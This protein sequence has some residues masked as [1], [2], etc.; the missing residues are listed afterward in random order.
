MREKALDNFAETLESI[1]EYAKNWSPIPKRSQSILL[2]QLA[3]I[4][5]L[6]DTQNDI[7]EP[8]IEKCSE[9]WFNFL[10]KQNEKV[11]KVTERSIVSETKKNR[12]IHNVMT[13]GENITISLL[14]WFQKKSLKNIS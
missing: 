3:V 4:E 6:F 13:V 10:D 11:E 1:A 2:D 12:S 14:R 8:F 7:D 9:N 5:S